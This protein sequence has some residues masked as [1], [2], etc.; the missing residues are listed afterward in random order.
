MTVDHTPEVKCEACDGTG[1]VR[2]EGEHHGGMGA[3][4]D[5]PDEGEHR[6]N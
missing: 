6:G 1:E 5:G 3:E 2:Y 4:W